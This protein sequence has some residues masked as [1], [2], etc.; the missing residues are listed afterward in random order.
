[1]YAVSPLPGSQPL[2][3]NV[4]IRFGVVMCASAV[5]TDTCIK[6]E[7]ESRKSTY[8]LMGQH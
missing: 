7:V 3:F 6:K 1:M 4:Q 5:C 2:N 8:K